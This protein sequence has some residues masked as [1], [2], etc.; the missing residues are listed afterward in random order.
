MKWAIPAKTFLVGEYAALFDGPALVLTTQPCF[1]ISLT[2]SPGLSGIHPESPAG[3]WWFQQPTHQV[4][5]EWFDPYQ[6]RGGLGASSAQF[7]GAYLASAYLHQCPIIQEDLLQAYHQAA[8]QSRGLSPS[9]YD[10]ISQSMYGCVYLNRQQQIYQ[11]FTWP[12]SDISF[13]LL[14]TGNK[15]ATHQHLQELSQINHV[16]LLFNIC[17]SAHQALIYANSEQ[18][19]SAINAYYQQLLMMS[20]VAP[21]TIAAVKALQQ[22]DDVLAAKGCGAL[23]ADV[24]LVIVPKLSLNEMTNRLTASGWRV[25]CQDALT[26]CDQSFE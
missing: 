17:E 14:H 5:L 6:G 11:S 18:F 15:L 7:L 24:I 8:W 4:G 2:P 23:G 21:H 12:F 26:S 3:R 16:D 20:L 10:V 13:I 19:V 9:G 22:Q 25:I 1:E